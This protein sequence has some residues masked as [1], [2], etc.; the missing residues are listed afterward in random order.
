MQQVQGINTDMASQWREESRRPGAEV[1][2][3]L[4]A[5]NRE[6][7]HHVEGLM[8]RQGV[9]GVM[10]S[11]GRVH[12]VV[13]AR[14]GSPFAARKVLSTAGRLLDRHL[15]EEREERQRIRETVE[16][17]L[18]DYAWNIQL[19]GYRLLFDML[20]RTA[21]DVSLLNPISKRLYPLIASDY[22]LKIHQIE[23]NIRYLFDDLALRERQGVTRSRR[24]LLLDGERSL[25]VGR[26]IARLSRE[27]WDRLESRGIS[28]Q[29]KE[30]ASNDSPPH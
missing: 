28:G 11:S 25:P 6:L 2:F 16:E 23:R 18:S 17:I 15:Q 1:G 14:R 24:R 30:A 4:V 22:R 21:L 29:N 8:N 12:Y 26:T 9:F 20:L 10:D 5:S 13:D 19:R 3:Y 7:L 27:V